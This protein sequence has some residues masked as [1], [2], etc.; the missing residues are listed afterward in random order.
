LLLRGGLAGCRGL[1]LRLCYAQVDVILLAG[2][3]LGLGA[4]GSGWA[5]GVIPVVGR[6]IG[7]LVRWRLGVVGAVGSHWGSQPPSGADRDTQ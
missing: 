3:L 1:L 5:G 2:T 6:A 7:L 4:D